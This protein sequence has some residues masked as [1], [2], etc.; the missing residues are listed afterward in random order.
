MTYVFFRE[1]GWYPID[2]PDD[3]LAQHGEEKCIRDYAL[4][5]PGTLKVERIDGSIA[6]QME[7][8]Q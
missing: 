3:M 8:A 7:A 6:W 4:H 5:N 1:E 2:M